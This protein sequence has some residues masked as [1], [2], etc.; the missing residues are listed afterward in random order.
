MATV[1]LIAARSDTALCTCRKSMPRREGSAAADKM[2]ILVAGAFGAAARPAPLWP[3]DSAR[4]EDAVA[5]RPPS[6]VTAGLRIAGHSVAGLRS[7]SPS[8]RSGGGGVGRRGALFD[9]AECERER[10]R[11]REREVE[12]EV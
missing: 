9:E 7:R 1:T 4:L 2:R 11:E 6:G 5:P 10:E 8:P 3:E 12:R